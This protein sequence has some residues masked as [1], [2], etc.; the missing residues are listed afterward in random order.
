MPVLGPV[1]AR[2]EPRFIMR[3]VLQGG[4]VDKTKLPG[5][6][7]A[8]LQALADVHRVTVPRTGHFSALERPGT[9]ARILLDAAS[10]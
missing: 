9:M 4:Y 8:D 1:F 6:F 7:V 5:D 3:A 10:S 2:L